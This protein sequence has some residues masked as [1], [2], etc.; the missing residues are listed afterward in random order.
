[1]DVTQTAELAPPRVSR[2]TI[3]LSLAALGVVFGDIGT[4]PLYAVRE[5]FAGTHPLA[6]TTENVLGVLSLL[7]WTLVL[8]VS[9][10]Y[11]L[12]VMRVDNH[13][14]GGILALLAALRGSP[15]RGRPRRLLLVLGVF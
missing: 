4:S 11:I 13:G 1:M 3:G 2:G 15:W 10:K 8:V 7:V 5:C 12:L 9:V 14:E 6:A